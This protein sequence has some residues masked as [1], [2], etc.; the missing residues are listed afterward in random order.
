MKRV[1]SLS[2]MAGALAI[3]A[4]A[5]A[6]ASPAAAPCTPGAAYNPVC[7]VDQNGVINITDIQLAAGHWNQAGVFTSGGWDLTGNA[8]TTPGTNFVGTTDGAALELH[9]NGERALRLEPFAGLPNVVGGSYANDVSSGVWAATI[10]GGGSTTLP[11]RVTDQ[12]GAI[13]GG[14]GNTAGDNAGT[15]S[16]HAFAT[17]GGGGGN[18]ASGWKSTVA[19]GWYNIASGE[20]SFVGGG[21]VNESTGIYSAIAGGYSNLA[22]GSYATVAGGNDN[23][24]AGTAATV[25]GGASNWASTYGVVSGGQSNTANP[26]GTVP[27]GRSNFASGD[28]SFAA[29]RRAKA[30]FDGDF[31]WA[32]STDAD[33]GSSAANQFVVRATGGVGLGTGAPANQLH[34]AAS[35]NS[36]ATPGNHVAQIQNTSPGNSADVLALKIGY[37]SNPLDSNNYITFF[38]GNDASVGSIEGN[39]SGG[40]VLAGPGNEIALW[41][42]KLDPAVTMTPGDLVGVVEGKATLD[43]TD[44]A[45]VFVASTGP[46]L[47]G[48]DPGEDARA[49]YV[50][51]TV[52]GLTQVRISGPVHPGDLI[53]PSGRGD[54]IGVA[55]RADALQPQQ[56]ALIA[57]QAWSTD[58]A[59]GERL[60]AA[61][62]GPDAMGPAVSSVLARNN[63]L[64]A[65]IAELA[66]RLA[67]LEQ[68]L[69]SGQ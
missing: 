38:K 28:Y 31:V 62:V 42:P 10:A 55:V 32:D 57:G 48:N 60:V 40:V 2:I 44:A 21:Q 6:S 56:L 67:T 51:V 41:L 4:S 12:Y 33:F 9:V 46:M 25:G 61:V 27:G 63:Q 20:E 36:S 7:D 49:G 69:A 19:G 59:E 54:G 53:L 17:V 34:V 22:N 47:T 39:G 8:G 11:N 3:L 37:T 30:Y 18:T 64:E 58:A 1:L 15:A 68:S 65:Q 45:R 13:G 23:Q 26:Y 66:A 24:A 14:Y 35:I 16:D 29:G 43:T 50:L 5:P 52:L